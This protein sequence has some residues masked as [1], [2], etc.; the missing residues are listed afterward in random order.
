VVIDCPNRVDI[1]S[2]Q[3][4]KDIL[5]QL[6]EQ[7]KYNIVINLTATKYMDSSG[8]GALVSRIAVAR[9]NNGD[10]CIAAAPKNI[11]DLFELTHLNQIIHCFENVELAAASFE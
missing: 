2:S 4:L 1:D 11:I 9:S 6:V 5:N 7:N 10:I 8:L 3:Q